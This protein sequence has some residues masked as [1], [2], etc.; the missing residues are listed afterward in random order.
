[1]YLYTSDEV[2]FAYRQK[3]L[4]LPGRIQ[5]AIIQL[6]C[7]YVCITFVIFTLI[8]RAVRGRFPQTQDL[9]KRASIG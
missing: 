2:V 4:F 3:S 1:M 5:G 9:W 7:L 6:V 8:A